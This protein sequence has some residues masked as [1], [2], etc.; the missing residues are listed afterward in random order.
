MRT[1]DPYNPALPSAFDHDAFYVEGEPYQGEAAELDTGLRC[2]CGREV[3]STLNETTSTGWAHV[4]IGDA[5]EPNGMLRV[6][7]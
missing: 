3:V 1:P 4:G 7:A 2:H 6:V 5:S